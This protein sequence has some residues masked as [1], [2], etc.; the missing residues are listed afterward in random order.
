[1]RNN[2]SLDLQLP[3]A[4]AIAESRVVDPAGSGGVVIGSDRN[5]GR[6]WQFAR[7]IPTNA[8]H[9]LRHTGEENRNRK[10]N[11]K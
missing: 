5:L 4:I 9:I 10:F 1:M 2:R 7:S 6:V 11:R 3:T 8:R